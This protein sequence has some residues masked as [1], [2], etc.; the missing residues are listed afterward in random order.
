MR[1]VLDLPD[2]SPEA[3]LLREKP[4]PVAYVAGLLRCEVES[5][6]PSLADQFARARQLAETSPY[7]MR[8]MAEIVQHLRE[9]RSEWDR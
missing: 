9:I 2:D 6:D 7:R 1:L 5:C 4:D 8:D 3:L